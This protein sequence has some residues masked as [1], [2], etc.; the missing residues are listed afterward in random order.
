MLNMIDVDSFY[1][2]SPVLQKVNFTVDAG[3]LVSVLGRNGVGKTT[4]MR[5][6]MGLTDRS[7]GALVFDGDEIGN[8]PTNVRAKRGISYV[9]Q[10]RGILPKFTVRENILMG[11][12]ARP[13]KVR[14]LPELALDMFPY[15]KE[16]LNRQAG[17]LSGGQQQQVAISRA[18]AANPKVLL[19]DEPTEGIQPNIVE[20]IEQAIMTLKQEMKLTVILVEQNV[21]FARRASD[22]FVI[23]EKGRVAAN[24]DIGELTDDV[25]HR[26]M[27]V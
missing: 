2:N 6:I 9:P 14:D 10:G 18:L 1:G 19:L 7:T 5:T 16:N 24:G 4:L 11:T 17:N 3:K 8:L 20:L 12:F 26:H 15:L 23:L 27:T 22:Q 13:G 25:V 21:P